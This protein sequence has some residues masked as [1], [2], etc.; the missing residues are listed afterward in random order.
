MNLILLL[1]LALADKFHEM[2]NSTPD[3]EMN[4]RAELGHKVLSSLQGKIKTKIS[5]K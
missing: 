4:V 1:G 5:I 2:A 3:L